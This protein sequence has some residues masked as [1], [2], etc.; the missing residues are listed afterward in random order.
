MTSELLFEVTQEEDGGF[1][2][3]AVGESI[4]TQA[5]TWEE[6]RDMALD[7]VKCHFEEGAAPANIRLHL[8]REEILSAA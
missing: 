3:H 5:S 6:L 8:V 4:F 7:A 2:A 1:S